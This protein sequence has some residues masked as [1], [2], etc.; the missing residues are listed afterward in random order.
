MT[1]ADSGLRQV[2]TV[3]RR[4]LRT[5]SFCLLPLAIAACSTAQ[6]G[7]SDLGA[8]SQA[9][10][11][12]DC[13]FSVTSDVHGINKK[14]F[15]AKIRVKNSSGATS[16]NF[17]V[18]ID[19]GGAQLV[20]SSKG[21]FTATE[22]GYLLKPGEKTLGE[23][24]DG[25]D[26]QFEL[27]FEGT[28]TRLNAYIQ[29]NN[30]VACDQAAPT[31]K[32]TASGDFFTSAGSLRLSATATDNVAVSKVVFAQDGVPIGTATT[33]PYTLN[34]PISKALNG[35]HRYS[36]T[37]YDLSGNQGG[38]T[39]RVLVAIDNKFF[40]S[41]STT[42]AD[43]T[44]FTAHFNQL[45]PGNAGKWGSV[46]AT[47]DQMN[48][49]DLDAAYSFAKANKIP[50][51][52][53]TLVWGQQQ[54]NW[55][56]GLSPEEQLAELE[57]W[58]SA[59][60]ERYPDVQ[61]IDVVN[62]PLHAP[63]SYAAALGGAGATGWD[64]VIK[65]FEMARA[66]FPNAELILNDYSILTMASTTQD[67]LKVVKVLS[68]R[69]LIDGIGEQAHF[70][71]RAPELS[72]LTANLNAFA[73]T[74]LPIYI[75]ELDLN[76][77]DDARQA[78]RMKELFTAFWSN[79]SVLGVTHWGHRQGNMWQE[80]AYLIRTDGSLRPALTWVECFKAGGTNCPVPAYVP[81]PRT[82]DDSGI[83]LEAEQYDSAHALLPAGEVVAYASNGSWFAFDQ[84]AF[85]NNW[86]SLNVTYAQGGTSPVQLTVHFDS[87]DSP[88][89][90]TVP[91]APTGSWGTSKTVSVPWAPTNVQKNVFVRFNGGGANVD[92]LQFAAPSGTGANLLTDSDLELGTKAGWSSWGGGTIANTTARALTGTHSIAMTARNGNSPLV[93]TLT[94]AVAPGRTY[95]VSL[96]ATVG[97]AA[98][99]AYVT[100][101]LQCVGGETT[102]GRLGGWENTKTLSDGQWQEFAGDLVVPDCQLANVAFWLEG[103]AAGV[104]LYIDH[105]SVR[106][107]T[108]RNVITNGT[109]ESGTS[110][111][112]TWGGATLTAASDR[113]HGGA[114]SLLVS[115]RS[116]NYPAATDLTSVVKAGSSYP[117]SL[118]VSVRSPD[119]TAKA[120]NVTQA[121]TCKAADG[122]TSTSYA[123][124][125]GPTNVASSAD[126]VQLAGTIAVPNCTLTQLQLFVEGG[127]GADLYV[128]DVQVMDNSAASGNL[129][130]D[131]TFE[132]GP[133]GWGGWGYTSLAV[134]NTTSHAGSSS[135]KG[136]GMQPNGALSRDIKPVVSAGKRYRATAWVSVGNLAAGS[137]SVKFQTIQS[138]NATGSDS[139][140][141]LSG[142]T[143]TNG[144]WKQLTGT[145]DLSACSSVEKLQLFVGAD[146][147][148]L[149]VDDVTLTPIP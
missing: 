4:S 103:P 109:F 137:G 37:A 77:A 56:D 127:A 113:V 46:E 121:T 106:G 18:L 10:E 35:R 79:R 41:I 59:L 141:W 5:V 134:V 118:W 111:W 64:W 117:F 70:Y 102:Y 83:T 92:K 62:E 73:A 146:G 133:G 47:R 108:T 80:N 38:E 68:D 28:Y 143:V 94:S 43:Y 65:A 24:E 48:W 34:V 42:A 19:A 115:G 14:Q 110:G 26:Y 78:I 142:D 89:V 140:P 54:P 45:T 40:G 36:A 124:I 126:W 95:K 29:S 30:G 138:C 52:L 107:V 33:A 21:T 44:N 8:A 88:P 31:L 69:G 50:F 55:L 131:G 58:M 25:D 135:L 57:Q 39:K 9:V 114:K 32:L 22:N 17:S 13:G 99:A 49:T 96:W 16:T 149:Y 122:T 2:N 119:G 100:T 85:R 112:F 66:H 105:A 129:I 123:W 74:G 144:S 101:A 67:Y 76:F 82:G 87:L 97:G 81:Q 20:Q 71:E 86:D 51:K 130:T 27:K 63:P 93:Q 128:D 1:H 75:T 3:A 145:V 91:L 136:T 11:G 148:D 125:A 132:S 139:Y 72:V 98:S 120:I 6:G 15:H 60:A 7:D 84:V 116:G 61:M 90:A 147:G 23:L 12:A 53:H 104:D